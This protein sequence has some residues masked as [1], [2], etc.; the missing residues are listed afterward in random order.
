MITNSNLELATL[1][2]Q[3]ATLLEAAPKAHM[4]APC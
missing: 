1:I 2:L 4:A 3:E